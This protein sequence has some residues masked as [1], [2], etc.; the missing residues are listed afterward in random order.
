[1]VHLRLDKERPLSED[2]NLEASALQ[3][4][5]V[6][7]PAELEGLFGVVKQIDVSRD[8][9]RVEE[10]VQRGSAGDVAFARGDAVLR[11]EAADLA[12]DGCKSH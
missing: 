4:P 9:R 1:V 5:S 12:L 3:E 10:R 7:L 11:Y 8:P 2:S 6:S